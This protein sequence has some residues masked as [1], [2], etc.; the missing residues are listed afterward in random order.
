MS[1]QEQVDREHRRMRRGVRLVAVERV[2]EEA[3]T[4]LISPLFEGDA[5]LVALPVSELGLE[6]PAPGRDRLSFVALL[7][8]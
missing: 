1:L 8:E 7:R 2:V 4:D 5:S 3:Q 6:P